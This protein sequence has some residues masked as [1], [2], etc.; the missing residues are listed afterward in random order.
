M[1]PLILFDDKYCNQLHDDDRDE[2]Q[3]FVLAHTLLA[4]LPE[5][6]SMQFLPDSMDTGS[7]TTEPQNLHHMLL[8]GMREVATHVTDGLE[9]QLNNNKAPTMQRKEGSG[10]Q[11][12]GFTKYMKEREELQVRNRVI[13]FKGKEY[14]VWRNK[15][16]DIQTKVDSLY[17]KFLK[18]NCASNFWLVVLYYFYIIF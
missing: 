14:S 1:H 11:E 12:D 15:L 6:A 7:S 8:A 2:K 4:A 3:A 18:K 16:Q 10:K 13:T 9:T 17:L 5:D